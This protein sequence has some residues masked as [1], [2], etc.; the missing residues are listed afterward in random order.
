MFFYVYILFS[1]RKITDCFYTCKIFV[2]L[3]FFLAQ[4][5]SKEPLLNP[6]QQGGRN[7][8]LATIRK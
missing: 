7:R 5:E 4:K 3:F 2:H 6:P 8:R 1:S